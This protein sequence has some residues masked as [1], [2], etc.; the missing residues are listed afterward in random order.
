MESSS[1]SKCWS[2][3]AKPQA[4]LDYGIAK[5]HQDVSEGMLTL[6]V[7]GSSASE[8]PKNRVRKRRLA[9]RSFARARFSE[10]AQKNILIDE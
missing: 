9:S 10:S 3:N 2:P 6:I 1:V 8:H 7:D 4:D 5:M